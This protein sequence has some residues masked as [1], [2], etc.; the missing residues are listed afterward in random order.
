MTRE[1][2]PDFFDEGP[3]G[4]E[5][6]DFAKAAAEDMQ[7]VAVTVELPAGVVRF[8]ALNV[9][10]R[11]QGGY[12]TQAHALLLRDAD[13]VDPAMLRGAG[14]WLRDCALPS[15][16]DRLQALSIW[17]EIMSLIEDERR[18]GDPDYQPVEAP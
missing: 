17:P 5:L 16:A 15:V 6:H 12:T 10:I 1:Y 18:R 13:G 11:E 14:E 7:P 2:Q 4:T 8:L 9:M 3:D